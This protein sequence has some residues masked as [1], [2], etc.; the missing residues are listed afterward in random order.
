MDLHRQYSGTVATIK[1]EDGDETQMCVDA[2]QSNAHLFNKSH[3]TPS[4]SK[5]NNIQSSETLSA[6]ICQNEWRLSSEPTERI[7][8]GIR[9]SVK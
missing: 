3:F 6:R 4:F 8:P 1:S 5:G 2:Q 7:Y 9:V